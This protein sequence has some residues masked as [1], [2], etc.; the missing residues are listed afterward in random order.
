MMTMHKT[1]SSKGKEKE[2]LY[3]KKGEVHISKE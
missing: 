1:K 3:K 2:K